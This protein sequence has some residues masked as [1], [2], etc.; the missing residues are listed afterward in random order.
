MFRLASLALLLVAS[1]ALPIG[2]GSCNSPNPL[3]FTHVTTDFIGGT[4]LIDYGLEVRIGGM[5]LDITMPFDFPI[6]EEVSIE[7]VSTTENIFRGAL[8]K[9]YKSGV[10]T[11]SFL[12]PTA[13]NASTPGLCTVV[14]AGGIGHTNNKNKTSIGGTLFVDEPMDGLILEVTSVISN[15]VSAPVSEWYLSS[16]ALNAVLNLT[17][18]PATP[19]PV[20]D[21][22]STSVPVTSAPVNDAPVTSAPVGM[23]DAPVTAAPATNAPTDAIVS[24]APVTM[25]PVAMTDPPVTTAPVTVTSAPVEVPTTSAPVTTPPVTMTMAP[26]VPV[27][28]VGFPPPAEPTTSAPVT[29]LPPVGTSMAPA[30]MAPV[31]SAPV[32]TAPSVPSMPSSVPSDIPSMGMPTPPTPKPTN[33]FVPP[34]NGDDDSGATTSATSM[35]TSLVV[36]AI[37]A[38][39]M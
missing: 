26:V 14:N 19:V 39:L 4:N 38:M 2:P 35:V 33:S 28:P 21:A 20:T 32:T 16:F 22:P 5:T 25:S 31:T 8:F 36:G 23:T 18:A 3:G 30:T 29:T 7:L 9:L 12:A 6:D 1:R 24:A 11:T 37:V 15:G 27:P 10:D 17:F 13:P 34:T